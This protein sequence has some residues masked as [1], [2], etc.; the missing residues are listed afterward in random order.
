M[1][2]KIQKHWIPESELIARR[3]RLSQVIPNSSLLVIPSNEVIYRNSDIE[4]K[5]RQ[6]SNFWYFSGFNEP[7]SCLIAIKDED[8]TVFWL[9]CKSQ[10]KATRRDLWAGDIG[11]IDEAKEKTKIK[12]VDSIEGLEPFLEKNI[13]KYTNIFFSQ[14]QNNYRL[15]YLLN[16]LTSQYNLKPK[17]V[18][19]ITAKLRLVKSPWEIQQMKISADIASEAHTL[20]YQNL[21]Y[22][23]PY[24]EEY[25]NVYEFQIEWEFLRYFGS[26]GADWSYWPIIASGNNANTIHY[27]ANN[28]PLKNNDLILIDAGCEYN[29]YAS[30]ITRTYPISGKFDTKQKEIYELVLEANER[31]IEEV[32]NYKTKKITLKDLH[33]ISVE[34]L[35][36]GLITLGIFDCSYEEIIDKKLYSKF[37]PY[38]V[39]HWLGLDTHDQG[40]YKETYLQ[41]GMAFTIEPGLHFLENSETKYA[42]IG[43]RIEDNILITSEGVEITTAK[44]KKKIK[45][46]ELIFT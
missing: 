37:Y 38:S 40:E 29:Y 24:S 19:N 25:P 15:I 39:G 22:Y 20:I 41:E 42:G 21:P 3:S 7:S 27:I 1:Q 6:E 35:S 44:A 17:E 9:F 13:K 28:N 23:P 4:H 18:S 10:D 36:K 34:I 32:K 46:L 5:F 2:K 31:T 45:D 43:I 33:M 11:G 14:N 30:D 12:F 16:R 8:E 26:K